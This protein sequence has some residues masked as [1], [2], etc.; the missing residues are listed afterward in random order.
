MK[1]T[2]IES[3]ATILLLSPLYLVRGQGT[4]L[5]GGIVTRTDVEYLADISLDVRDVKQ[6]ITGGNNKAAL[7][8]YIGGRNSARDDGDLFKLTELS[9]ILVPPL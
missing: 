2:L 1:L 8:I 3:L 6:S 4:D 7:S 9:T 5:G